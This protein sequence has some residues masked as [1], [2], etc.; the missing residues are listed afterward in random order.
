MQKSKKSLLIVIIVII[1]VSL[2]AGGYYFIIKKA[3]KPIIWDGTYK[4]TGNLACKGDIP[5]LSAIPM[6]TTVSVTSNKIVEQIQQTLKSFDIDKH[7]R[8]TEIAQQT[9][10][11]V[12]TDIKADYQFY[13][14][15]GAYKFN[16][17]GTAS[18][19]AVKDDKTYTSTCSGTAK[20][21]RQ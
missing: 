11:G 13:M 1:I 12:T 16:A 4:M 14:E 15:D 7:G 8:A 3:A 21:V 9:G 10:S 17:T 5:G 18:I 2:G 20:G 6:D 19:S